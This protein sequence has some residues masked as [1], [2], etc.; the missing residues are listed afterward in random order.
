MVEIALTWAGSIPES[1]FNSAYS[2]RWIGEML[3]DSEGYI[4]SSCDR[5]AAAGSVSAA[6]LF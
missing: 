5:T 2:V 1:V 3:T 6:G 4:A